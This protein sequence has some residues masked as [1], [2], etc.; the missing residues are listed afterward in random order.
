MKRALGVFGALVFVATVGAALLWT[1]NRA[2]S[3]AGDATARGVVIPIVSGSVVVYL[4][5]PSSGPMVLINSGDDPSAAAI[6]ERL[7]ALGRSP[8][9]V[10]AVFMTHGSYDHY[11]GLERFPNA[12]VYASSDDLDLLDH[13]RRIRSPIPRIRMRLFGR[14]DRPSNTRTVIPGERVRVAEVEL[15]CIGLPGVT[16][17]SMAYRYED[18]I[19]IGDSL[20]PGPALPS[21][22]WLEDDDALRATLPRLARFDARWL[23]TS[24]QGFI[25]KP[26]SLSP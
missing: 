26:E 12:T 19:F 23:A 20:W 16:Q 14:P 22:L 8:R 9:E 24:R 17:G 25:E 2:P 11:A 10:A 21:T 1:S 7:E 18:V 5:A 15:E 13:V 4:I 6:L 3:P